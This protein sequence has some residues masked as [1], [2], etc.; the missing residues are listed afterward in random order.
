MLADIGIQK[1]TNL[2]ISS[3]S[4][5]FNRQAWMQDDEAQFPVKKVKTKEIIRLPKLILKI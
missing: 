4:I 1:G 2:N 3:I 5:W